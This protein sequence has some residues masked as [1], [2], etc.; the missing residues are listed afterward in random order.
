[1][2]M[3][4]GS[5]ALTKKNMDFHALVSFLVVSPGWKDWS[6]IF[7][8]ASSLKSAWL[9]PKGNKV[10]GLFD[11]S[12]Y[13][14]TLKEVQAMCDMAV[15]RA[16]ITQDKANDAKLEEMIPTLA[17]SVFPKPPDRIVSNRLAFHGAM[18]R[19]Y[20]LFAEKGLALSSATTDADLSSLVV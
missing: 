4:P 18:K 14:S 3:T 20:Y 12:S 10:S 9:G 13:P 5:M 2:L 15:L 8:G 17:A 16:Y 11:S 6:A 7:K 19:M 1:M